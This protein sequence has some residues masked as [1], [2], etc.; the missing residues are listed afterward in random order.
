MPDGKYDLE[1]R[2]DLIPEEPP[3][4]TE[5]SRDD[6][7]NLI[8]DMQREADDGYVRMEITQPDIEMP[9][10]QSE[11]LASTWRNGAMESSTPASPTQNSPN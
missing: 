4:L 5:N 9:V 3:S 11:S 10:I 2:A 7:G 8:A 1:Q 6:E